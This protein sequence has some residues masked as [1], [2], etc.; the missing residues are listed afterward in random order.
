M[1]SS[2][3]SLTSSLKKPTWGK[4]S[5]KGERQKQT[6][7][8]KMK[9]DKSEHNFMD[10]CLKLLHHYRETETDHRKGFLI[11][12]D[13]KFKDKCLKLLHHSQEIETHSNEKK[14]I[15]KKGHEK[16]MDV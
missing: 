13:Q 2:L 16:F 8:R 1:T 9:N 6:Q 12:G 3:V 14:K 4:S 11:K 5:E 10:K 15:L 7:K